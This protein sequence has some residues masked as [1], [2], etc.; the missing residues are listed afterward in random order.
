MYL[1]DIRNSKIIMID[2]RRLFLLT[3]NLQK[4]GSKKSA[5]YEE[6]TENNFNSAV[7]NST[8]VFKN[9]KAT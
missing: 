9:I 4:D 6:L 2:V 8:R 1:S 7:S 5:A 3:S